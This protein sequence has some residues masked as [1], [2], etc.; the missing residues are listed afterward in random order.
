MKVN[1]PTCSK[2][3]FIPDE[4][5][6]TESIKVKCPFC[7]KDFEIKMKAEK[8]EAPAEKPAGAPENVEAPKAPAEKPPEPNLATTDKPAGGM[9]TEE[10]IQE[11]SSSFKC[12]RCNKWFIA[13][14][15]GT[16][17][18]PRCA[19]AE[20]KDMGFNE[21]EIDTAVSEIITD[22]AEGKVSEE[23]AMKC[24]CCTPNK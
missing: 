17:V 2:G 11:A 7:G 5:L 21:A 23:V 10:S 3:G 24:L 8:P 12:N 16:V 15:A 18:C 9:Q 20:V 1:C 6:V 19:S 13:D 14:K 4:K 22:V